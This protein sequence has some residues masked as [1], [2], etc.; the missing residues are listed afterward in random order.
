MAADAKAAPDWEAIEAG[1]RAGVLSLR[2]LGALHGVSHTAIG[3]KAR[4]EGWERDLRAKIAAQAEALVI[5]QAVPAS[6]RKASERQIIEANAEAIAT[7][8]GSHRA[9][10][11]RARSLVVTLLAELEQ[12]TDNAGMFE[13][14]GE[15]MENPDEK[16]LD[17]LREA[18]NKIIGFGGR[19][20]SIKSLSEAMKNL[21]NLE[22]EAYGIGAAIETPPGPLDGLSHGGLKAL[23]DAIATVR[24]AGG[25]GPAS[26]S[27]ARF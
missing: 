10:I 1:Y 21:V 23:H 15:L 16:G 26:A 24:A 17:R 18:Y 19:V 22:R 4:T 2:E 12:Q 11:G 20:A 14:L 7:V 5:R 13:R 25:A 27:G 9:D 3:K 6:E 8:R